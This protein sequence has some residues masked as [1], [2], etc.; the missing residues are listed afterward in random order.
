MP[1]QILLSLLIVFSLNSFANSENDCDY[2]GTQTQMNICALNLYKV[3]N[4]KLNERY[5]LLMHE[6]E[7]KDKKVLKTSQRRWLNNEIL[8]AKIGLRTQLVDQFTL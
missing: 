3:S 8:F 5:S 2:N 7:N 6:L 4:R 1:K